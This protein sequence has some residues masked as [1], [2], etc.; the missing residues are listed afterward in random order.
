V[1][2][3]GCCWLTT[4][5]ASIATTARVMVRLLCVGRLDV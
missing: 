2:E 3:V 1:A 4:R 5:A